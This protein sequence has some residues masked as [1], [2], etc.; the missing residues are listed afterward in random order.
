MTLTPAHRLRRL[1]GLSGAVSEEGLNLSWGDGD[2]IAATETTDAETNPETAAQ[3]LAVMRQISLE[4]EETRR[5]VGA[6]G[7]R[8]ASGCQ[9][10]RLGHAPSRA[11]PAL[12]ASPRP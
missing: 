1:S 9:S 6:R 11:V 4:A 5:E 10:P 2:R 3:E 12:L 8:A 7:L